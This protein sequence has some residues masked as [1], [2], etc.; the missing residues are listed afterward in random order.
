M[1]FRKMRGKTKGKIQDNFGRLCLLCI[2]F[3]TGFGIL[4]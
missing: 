3:R 1:M 4:K 2:F